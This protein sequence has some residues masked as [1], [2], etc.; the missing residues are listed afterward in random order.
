[1]HVKLRFVVAFLAVAA[2]VPLALA[3]GLSQV[4]FEKLHADLSPERAAW[5]AVPWKLS[6]TEASALAAKERKPVYMLVRSG[7]PLGCV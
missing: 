6:I 2:T 1:V 7:H 4:E 5:E 3:E